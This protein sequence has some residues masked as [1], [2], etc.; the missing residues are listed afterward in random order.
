M[1]D[2]FQLCFEKIAV[3]ATVINTGSNTVHGI[4]S[5]TIPWQ[6]NDTRTPQNNPKPWRFSAASHNAQWLAHSLNSAGNKNACV[7]RNNDLFKLVWNI[8][9]YWI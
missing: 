1:T 2:L 4:V 8:Q 9:L 3:A 7:I 5:T 6:Q